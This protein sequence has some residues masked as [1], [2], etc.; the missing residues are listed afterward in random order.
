MAKLEFK[1]KI[2]KAIIITFFLVSLIATT[3]ITCL[4]PIAVANPDTPTPAEW[5][6]LILQTPNG[7]WRPE[8]G[9]TN[10]PWLNINYDTARTGYTPSPAPKT[11]H[12][13]WVSN[14]HCYE[15]ALP[16]IDEGR[17]FVASAPDSTLFCLDAYTGDVIWT[18]PT[19]Q[20]FGEGHLTISD[21]T[22]YPQRLAL[23]GH[24][25]G[26]AQGGFGGVTWDLPVENYT[27][28]A[29]SSRRMTRAEIG[30]VSVVG[31]QIYLQA[32]NSSAGEGLYFLCFQKDRYGQYTQIWSTKIDE[33]SGALL[34]GYAVANGKIYAKTSTPDLV[35]LNATDGTLLWN[36]DPFTG[37]WLWQTPA[38]ID[39]RVYQPS[40]VA[41][42]LWCLD[43]ETGDLLWEHK[44]EGNYVGAVTGA[45][46]KIY[47]TGGST[48]RKVYALD[49]TNGKLIW[50]FTTDGS[51]STMGVTIADG[52]IYFSCF[53]RK[54]FELGEGI[55]GRVYCLNADTG[56]LVWSWTRT[57]SNGQRVSI[58]DGYAYTVDAECAIYCIGPGPTSTTIS[59]TSSQF[60]AGES[61]VISGSVTDMSPF[62][63]ERPDLQ[64]SLVAGVPVILSYVTDDSWM[65]FATVTTDTA[66]TF[67]HTWTPP[68]EGAYKVVARFEGNDSYHWSSAQEVIQVSS[69]PSPDGQIQPE[70]EAPLITTELAIILAVVAVAV[71]GV[72]GY[73]ILKKRQ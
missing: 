2:N 8:P 70:P 23:D 38:V 29:G 63:Q 46:G 49:P 9:V 26:Y 64:S 45:Y 33:T 25:Y 1:T 28:Y 39:G 50:D 30:L 17:V 72:V 37:D 11:N 73:W 48:D 7:A 47:L 60:T 19:P 66:G 62:S 13:L 61:V 68:S 36:S 69:A 57:I 5:V 27:R 71:I 56:E 10:Y 18:T 20:S 67:M 3:L 53:L 41:N 51:V 32:Y 22:I 52:N 21:G 34:F 31:D 55:P 40:G 59:V 4:L 42:S 24:F 35:C 44:T 6:N 58:A 14:V 65:D 16:A 54:E 43:A 15:L 12:T